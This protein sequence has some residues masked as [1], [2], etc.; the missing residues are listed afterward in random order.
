MSA[1]TLLGPA[2]LSYLTEVGEA[3]GDL[4]PTDRGDL[5]DEVQEHL[6]AIAE[7]E[8]D[9]DTAA[10]VARLGTPATYAAQ[11]RGAAG[12]PSSEWA[13][14]TPGVELPLGVSRLITATWS[15]LRS[16]APAWWALRGFLV[17]GLILTLSAPI[18][19]SVAAGWHPDRFE[20]SDGPSGGITGGG[21]YIIAVIVM[22]IVVS[23][24]IGL[25]QNRSGR[26]VWLA[27]QGFSLAGIAAL[28]VCPMWWIGPSFYAYYRGRFGAG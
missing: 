23:V 22:L 6:Q 10:L 19:G 5:L 18:A 25:R 17:T 11:L 9:L 16:L 15:Y 13:I 2:G 8:P 24:G 7:D 27:H 3:L 14:T 28:V 12:L 1:T 26:W 21:P 4:A 20:T